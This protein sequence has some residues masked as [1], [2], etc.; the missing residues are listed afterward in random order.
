MLGSDWRGHVSL[1]LSWDY[2]YLKCLRESDPG[3]ARYSVDTRSHTVEVNLAGLSELLTPTPSICTVESCIGQNCPEKRREERS[4]ELAPWPTPREHDASSWSP[5]LVPA[6]EH[7]ANLAVQGFSCLVFDVDHGI[8]LVDLP[9]LRERLA[10]FAYLLQ[11]THNHHPPDNCRFRVVFPLSRVATTQEWAPLLRSVSAKYG[12]TADDKTFALSTHF[13]LSRTKL[14]IEPIHELHDGAA[15][16]VDAELAD[17]K[18][19]LPVIASHG[20]RFSASELVS[21][22]VNTGPVDMVE[23]RKCLVHYQPKKDPDKHKKECLRR[24]A[25]GEA[26]APKGGRGFYAAWLGTVLAWAFPAG[27]NVDAAMEMVRPSFAAAVLPEDNTPD[28][29]PEAWMARARSQFETA[30]TLRHTQHLDWEKK[31]K[32]NEALAIKARAVLGLKPPRS[33]APVVPSVDSPEAPGSAAP[34]QAEDDDA[35]PDAQKR[36]KAQDDAFRKAF[37]WEPFVPQTYDELWMRG[38]LLWNDD[39]SKILQDEANAYTIL[40]YDTDWKDA[41][42]LNLV[43]NRVEVNPNVPISD[44][45]RN[46]SNL[47]HVA[48]RDWL[49]GSDHKL[50]VPPY[51]VR[52][53]IA[54]I[55]KESAYDPLREYLLRVGA[56][57]DG[58]SRDY[59]FLERY[60]AAI[61]TD[62]HGRDITDLVRKFSVRW[63]ISAVARGLTPGCKVD[64][65]LVLEGLQGRKKTT[66]FEALGGEWYGLSTQQLTD[67]DSYMQSFRCWIVELGELDSLSS[68]KLEKLK[69]HLS[70]RQD[71]FRPPYGGAVEDF[72]RRCVYV[73]STNEPRYLKDDT[74]NR[75]FW[76]VGCGALVDVEAVKRDRDQI[77]GEAVVRFLA[78]EKWWFDQDESEELENLT[79]QRLD[80]S[81]HAESVLTWWQQMQIKDRPAMVGMAQVATE[82]LKMNE[83]RVDRQAVGRVLKVLGF[84]R[85]HVTTGGH[86]HAMY[87]P[88]EAFRDVPYQ[89]AEAAK[90]KRIAGEMETKSAGEKLEEA[91][92]N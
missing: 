9:A 56:L 54:Q 29:T 28:N 33:V 30:A 37:G 91:L 57:W 47:L 45:A 24:V 60:C 75:R 55:A 61:C 53:R 65:V 10:P 82:A 86:R 13:Y 8:G 20:I 44:A 59:T 16:D 72:L 40:K 64:T 26:F 87:A 39:G 31:K 35:G 19:V 71:S 92:K 67:K 43:M 51:S 74:G 84:K 89:S 50:R 18:V 7:R 66:L 34:V 90:L 46:S 12:L 79:I 48:V 52:D 77:W 5:G 76:P 81:T 15:M 4:P 25:A 63:L 22:P 73:G 70:H 38:L 42:R 58:V 85:I 14:G 88:P 11:S 27:T 21:P 32:E 83:D 69:A 62:E 3:R 41:F 6:G 17:V 78:G 36:A 68:T 1:Y 23:L 80:T 2:E 49:A